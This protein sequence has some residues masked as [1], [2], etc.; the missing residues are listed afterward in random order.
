MTSAEFRDLDRTLA[1][2]QDCDLSAWDRDFVDDMVKRIG[3]YEEKTFVS[4]KQWEQIE[5]M[6]GQY[7]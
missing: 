3:R 5:R 6:K 4:A 7:L 1:K 2:L